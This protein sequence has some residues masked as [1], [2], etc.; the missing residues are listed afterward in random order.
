MNKQ[1]HDA[2]MKEYRKQLMASYTRGVSAG[3]KIGANYVAEKLGT[4]EE[5]AGLEKEQL[6]EKLSEG[7]A[8]NEAIKN[9]KLSIN[10]EET[11][12]GE[13]NGS[14]KM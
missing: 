5:W 11:L 4:P 13:K 7:L 6:I 12:E 9:N 10:N 2:I 1:Q 14:A 8:M 3:L